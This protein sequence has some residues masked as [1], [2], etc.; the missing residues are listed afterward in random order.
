[1]RNIFVLCVLVVVAV[2]GDHGND[3]Q[4]I[5]GGSIAQENQFPHQASIRNAR[6]LRHICGATIIHKRWFLTAASCVLFEFSKPASIRVFVGSRINNLSGSRHSI[7]KIIVHPRFSDSTVQNDIALLRTANDIIFNSKNT[8]A[9]NLPTHEPQPGL[10]VVMSGWGQFTVSIIIFT[11]ITQYRVHIL[12]IVQ[13]IKKIIISF[14][15][16]SFH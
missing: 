15:P 9:I 5:V 13:S 12:H 2:N 16:L 3:E 10:A 6:N 14:C 1:M 8:S 7:N 11:T 4:R